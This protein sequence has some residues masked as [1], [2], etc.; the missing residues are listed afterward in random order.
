MLRKAK[1]INGACSWHSALKINS[2]HVVPWPRIRMP[3]THPS[4]ASHYRRATLHPPPPP[5]DH[6]SHKAKQTA[7]HF[8]NTYTH[9]PCDKD[10]SHTAVSLCSIPEVSNSNPNS[11]ESRI[12]SLHVMPSYPYCGAL[13]YDMFQ[14]STDVSKAYTVAIFRDKYWTMNVSGGGVRQ[15]RWD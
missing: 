3:H 8:I 1:Q 14:S 10:T 9:L 15:T 2:V 7:H 13:R 4:S 11:T 6:A 5:Q 12:L